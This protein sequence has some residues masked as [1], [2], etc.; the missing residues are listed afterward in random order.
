MSERANKP[1]RR[2]TIFRGDDAV[3]VDDE[4]MPRQGIDQDV[5][6][7][8]Q[9]LG[10]AGVTEGVG[11]KT[12]MLFREPGDDGMSLVYC[13][14]KSH[15]VLPFHSHNVDCLYY[16]MGGELQMGSHVLK[17]GDGFFIPAG[18]GYGYEAGP[19]GVEVLEF[20][21]ASR[22]N[23]E[24]AKNPAQRWEK[25]ARTYTERADIWKVE[26]PPSGR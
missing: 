3:Q 2:M 5:M 11:E 26:E 25:I 17:K 24:F 8:L 6:A 10:E 12:V 14:F 9:K 18:L 21:N 22:F 19:E 16:V 7:G 13:W 15:Y 23:L 4:T 1:R 20:R